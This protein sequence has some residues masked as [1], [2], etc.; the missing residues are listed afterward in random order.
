MILV[1]AQTPTRVHKSIKELNP[2]FK[3]KLKK[4]GNSVHEIK[5][6]VSPVNYFL[7]ERKGLKLPSSVYSTNCAHNWF[8]M[9]KFWTI[10][11]WLTIL[12]AYYFFLFLWFCISHPLVPILNNH[13]LIIYKKNRPKR[14][15]PKIKKSQ[16]LLTLSE[17]SF[18]MF[19][20][21]KKR[22]KTV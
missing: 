19:D 12:G 2:S 10:P 6:N 18:E 17:N 3:T 16:C 1:G 9:F 21:R 15:S 22:S 13:T 14:R 8:T 11:S 5:K 20:K 4:K 7:T